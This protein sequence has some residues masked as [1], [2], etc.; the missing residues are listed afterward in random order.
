VIPS[1]SEQGHA[2]FIQF[3]AE[4][5]KMKDKMLTKISGICVYNHLLN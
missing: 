1:I 5:E 4:F 3:Y 2:D